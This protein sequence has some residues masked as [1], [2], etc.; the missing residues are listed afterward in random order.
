MPIMGRRTGTTGW[1][2]N[3][4][5]N[6]HDTLVDGGPGTIQPTVIIAFSNRLPYWGNSSGSYFLTSGTALLG[7][8]GGPYGLG[9]E[10]TAYR[11]ACWG[12]FDATTNAPIVYPAYGTLTV[13]DLRQMALQGGAQ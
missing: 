8:G 4:A 5:I 3:D 1:Q 13:Q 12:S 7:N 2:N 10:S 6:G 11:S 9:D